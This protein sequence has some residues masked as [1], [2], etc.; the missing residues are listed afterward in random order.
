MS[1]N[2][3]KIQENIDSCTEQYRCDTSLYLLS[4]LNHDYDIIIDHRVVEPQYSQDIV[5][6]LNVTTKQ[7]IS[8]LMENVKLPGSTGYDDQTAMYNTEHKEEVSLK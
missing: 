8:M 2:I 4:I 1:T 3:S 6:G 7:C 5:D